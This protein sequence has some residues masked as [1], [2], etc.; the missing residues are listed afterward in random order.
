[1]GQAR[2][3]PLITELRQSNL[4]ALETLIHSENM[5]AKSTWKEL[6]ISI[7]IVSMRNGDCIWLQYISITMFHV[8]KYQN[9]LV[10]EFRPFSMPT[11]YFIG[12]WHLNTSHMKILDRLYWVLS[13]QVFTSGYLNQKVCIGPAPKF[14]VIMF[15]NWNLSWEV[16]NEKNWP[17]DGQY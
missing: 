14:N 13:T 8:L 11:S 15:S 4:C 1:M 10:N 3:K 9:N 12:L 5:I 7:K 17:S 2:R 6:T 16:I